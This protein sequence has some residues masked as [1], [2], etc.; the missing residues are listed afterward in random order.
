MPILLE[1]QSSSVHSN[2]LA[3]IIYIIMD[4]IYIIM[5]SIDIILNTGYIVADGI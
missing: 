5:D 1:H 3:E 4:S 2:L